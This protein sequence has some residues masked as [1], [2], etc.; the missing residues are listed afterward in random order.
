MTNLITGIIGLAAV[1]IFM[2]FLLV[3]VP[4]PPLIIISVVVFLL[5][6]W[7]FIDSVRSGRST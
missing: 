5:L 1:A 7:D 6:A 3:W 4:A 2:G